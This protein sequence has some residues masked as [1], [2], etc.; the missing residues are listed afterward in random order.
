MHF[1]LT[2]A[3]GQVLDEGEARAEMQAGALV[4]SPEIGQ[5][6]RVRPADVT[7]VS[8]PAPYVVRLRLREGP[9][10][11]LSQLG[12]MRTQLLAELGEARVDDT[13]ESLLLRGVGCPEAF[14]GAANDTEAEIRLYEDTLV[15][16]PVAGEPL[17]VPYSFI[18]SVAADA[19]GYRISVNTND[20]EPIVLSRMARRTD[21]FLRLLREKVSAA[22]TRTGAFLGELLPGLGPIAARSVAAMLRDG[23]A[24]W[25]ADLDSVDAT[26]W[27]ALVAVA[28]RNQR[29]FG[30]ER[31]QAMGDCAIGFS[32]RLSVTKGAQ[33]AKPWKDSAAAPVIDHGG[34]P[35]M[36]GGM[37]GMMGAGMMASGGPFAMGFGAPFGGEGMGG[38]ALGMLGMGMMGSMGVGAPS[39][40]AHQPQ[41]RPDVTRGTLTPETTD[42]SELTLQ[43]GGD[44]G[45]EPMVLAFM[46]CH[47]GSHL[48]YEV[49]NVGDHASYVYDAPD[50]VAVRR[51]NRALVLIDFH[52]ES[53]YQDATSAGSQY[54]RAA[55]RLPELQ[56][57]RES[58]R[59]RAIHT[60]GWEQQLR[61]LF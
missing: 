30:V 53:I 28:T 4:V 61:G 48:V 39:G 27:P 13:V 60:D 8:E 18:E 38:M 33:G 5:P 52:V 29:A 25:K 12:A 32:Q 57:L 21:E 50:E 59:G 6:I 9:A 45:D 10:L 11:D 56:A 55:E 41:A 47:T 24:A 16:V 37:A 36:P 49:L 51:L 20:G 17:Q 44:N 22:R 35:T 1:R 34:T 43:G 42:Y 58:F 19:S 3:T 15:A 26:V 23:V 31:L 40:T 46:L 2:A 54:R 14:P 7:E